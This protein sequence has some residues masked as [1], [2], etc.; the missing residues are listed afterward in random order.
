MFDVL[1]RTNLTKGLHLSIVKTPGEWEA[2]VMP[3]GLPNKRQPQISIFPTEER[4][5]CPN[6]N[7]RQKTGI[8]GGSH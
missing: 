3:D 1:S 5:A 2:F 6:K 8:I 7:T 4:I